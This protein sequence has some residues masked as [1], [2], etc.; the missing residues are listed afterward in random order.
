MKFTLTK[1]EFRRLVDGASSVVPAKP[2]V[3]SLKHLL[4]RADVN[5]VHVTGSDVDN[6]VTISVR[7]DVAEEGAACLAAD[8]LQAIAKEVSGAVEVSVVGE[9][10]S[11]KATLKGSPHRWTVPGLPAA[12]FPLLQDFEVTGSW[13]AKGSALKALADL[14]AF[15]AK[16]P[17]KGV[18]HTLSNMLLEL[19]QDH[20][21]AVATDAQEFATARVLASG[22][23]DAD[24]VLLPAQVRKMATLV[25]G[26]DVVVEAGVS[27]VRVTGQG[28]SVM[29]RTAE[30]TYPDWRQII[31]DDS[32]CG[33]RVDRVA[34]L[35]AFRAV[36]VVTNDGTKKIEAAFGTDG[37]AVLRCNSIDGVADA[38]ATGHFSGLPTS[39]SL[40]VDRALSV[41][42]AVP[43]DRIEM[44]FKGE[45]LA[46]LIRAAPEM[47]GGQEAP[48]VQKEP[49]DAPWLY[50][51][52]PYVKG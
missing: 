48:Y 12:D 23:G 14:V 11:V 26:M 28:A 19:R 35:S 33:F 50:M 42:S 27:H 29:M 13:E 2:V 16:D 45:R 22:E 7:G 52:M 25:A 6:T 20:I 3:P 24:A 9:A 31:P 47:Q 17:E 41:L 51:L 37:G 40:H 32:R 36:A 46:V 18:A 34:I 49:T 10:D 44:R 43:A 15:A 39:T 8:K 4:I 5:G 38:S 1:D 21:R 30:A